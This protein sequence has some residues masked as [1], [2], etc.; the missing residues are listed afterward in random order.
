MIVLQRPVMT[1]V[2]KQGSPLMLGGGELQNLCLVPTPPLQLELHAQGPHLDQP[3]STASPSISF[4]LRRQFSE[5]KVQ[6]KVCVMVRFSLFPVNRFAQ[7]AT[8][9][10]S[11]ARVLLQFAF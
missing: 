11:D 7:Q 3:P 1:L 5:N 2:P 6:E 8:E 10:F 4:D 9:Q